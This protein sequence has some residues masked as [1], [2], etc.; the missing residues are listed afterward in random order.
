MHLYSEAAPLQREGQPV[1][2]TVNWLSADDST[3]TA[4][5]SLLKPLENQLW[6]DL[7]HPT[8]AQTVSPAISNL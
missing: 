7:V 3:Q 1:K 8:G 5:S 4:E 6:R 2:K